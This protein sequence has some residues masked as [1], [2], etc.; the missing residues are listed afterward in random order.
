[1]F[2]QNKA[3]TLRVAAIQMTS[4]LGMVGE[5]LEHA[6]PLIEQA[7]VQGAKLIVLP[8][9]CMTGYTITKQVWDM[10]EP[11]GGPIEQWLR[12]T[13]KRLGIYLGA[14]LVGTEGEDFYNTYL[15]TDPDGNVAGRVRKTQTEYMFFKAGEADSHVIDTAVGR[16]GIGICADNHRAIIPRIMQDRSVDIHLMPHAWPTAYRTSK[17]IKEQDIVDAREKVKSWPLL[18]A[19]LLG[20]PVIFVN[21]EGPMEGGPM[22]GI[23][24]KLLTPENFKYAGLSAIVDSDMTVKA[25]IGQVEGVAVADVMLDPARKLKGAI[26]SYGGWLDKGEPLLRKV[27]LPLDISRGKLSY[28]MSGD[29]KKKAMAVSK[30]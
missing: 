16:I 21:Q 4:R 20:V 6:L 5:N 25:R 27:I 18:Y 28:R 29:R 1:M 19:K 9:M 22:P 24:G 23:L 2:Q 8:E 15:L 12:N 11:S 30:P 26:I 10:A 3:R 17:L 13:S 7:A 14:G